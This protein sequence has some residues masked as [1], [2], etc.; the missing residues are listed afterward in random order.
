MSVPPIS[1]SCWIRL[2]NNKIS[3]FQTDHIALKFLLKRLSTT[4]TTD[5]QKSTELH[6]FFSKF[7]RLL[8]K[9]LNYLSK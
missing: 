5:I 8:A 1:S 9:E 6:D 4:T 7:E 2:A 3:G